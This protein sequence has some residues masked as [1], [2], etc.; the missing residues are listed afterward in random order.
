VAPQLRSNLDWKYRRASLFAV[1]KSLH[2][3]L[4]V[5]L[6]LQQL[7]TIFHDHV[8]AW[9]ASMNLTPSGETQCEIDFAVVVKRTLHLDCLVIG[10]CK[11][12]DEFNANDLANLSRIR[13]RCSLD[14]LSVYMV[15]AKLDKFSTAELDLIRAQPS[16]VRANIIMY[17]G[18]ELE[19]YQA[20]KSSK[21]VI[22]DMADLARA[23]AI[24]SGY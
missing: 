8:V 15:F 11:T 23:S 17:D 21:I 2:G 1:D 22:V 7:H 19:T 6:T 16:D 4:P 12:K 5:I 14:H 20:F 9:A 13:N 18:D 10:E 24:H 3:A